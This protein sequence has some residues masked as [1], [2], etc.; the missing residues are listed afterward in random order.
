MQKTHIAVHDLAF[1]H[2]PRRA[3]PFIPVQGLFGDAF[4]VAAGWAPNLN[5]LPIMKL[6]VTGVPPNGTFGGVS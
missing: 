6:V 1:D 5:G 2:R 4:A 3:G